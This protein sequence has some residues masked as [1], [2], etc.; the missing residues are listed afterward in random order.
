MSFSLSSPSPSQINLVFSSCPHLISW[1][2]G[3]L[4][5]SSSFVINSLYDF[6]QVLP[7]LFL[8]IQ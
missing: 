4:G 5:F 8:S 6:G 7:K 1:E 2:S 3:D